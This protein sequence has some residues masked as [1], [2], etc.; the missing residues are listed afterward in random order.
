[1]NKHDKS[2]WVFIQQ[3]LLENQQLLMPYSLAYA[4]YLRQYSTRIVRYCLN[5]LQFLLFWTF[6]IKIYEVCKKYCTCR[7]EDRHIYSPAFSGDND[8]KKCIRC[9]N[10]HLTKKDYVY[11]PCDW[12]MIV[13][14]S[15]M[16]LWYFY[17][18]LSHIH[19]NPANYRKSPSGLLIDRIW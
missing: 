6:I 3:L 7:N 19:C 5:Y 10:I 8:M 13:R 15:S 18:K 14:F 4:L 2:Q 12:I 17:Y 9:W 11:S 1:M 16:L